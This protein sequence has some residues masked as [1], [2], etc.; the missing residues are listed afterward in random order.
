MLSQAGRAHVRGT[1]DYMCVCV[2]A[3]VPCVRASCL[4]AQPRQSETRRSKHQVQRQPRQGDLQPPGA[5]LVVYACARVSA[6]SG[7]VQ[8]SV[9]VCAPTLV[10]SCVP[11]TFRQ[12]LSSVVECATTYF[13]LNLPHFC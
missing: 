11:P 7:Q 10:V 3:R 5:C 12:V 4:P 8:T 1:N 6:K 2:C 9:V 13:F